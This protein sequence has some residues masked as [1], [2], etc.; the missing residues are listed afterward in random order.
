MKTP[1]LLLL[2]AAVVCG[3]SSRVRSLQPQRRHVVITQA[4]AVERRLRVVGALGVG[5]VLVALQGDAAGGETLAPESKISE[6][7]GRSEGRLEM[8]VAFHPDVLQSEMD[9]ILLESGVERIEHPDLLPAHRLVRISPEQIRTISNW[10]EVSRIFSA[11]DSLVSGSPITGCAGP[12]T[13]VGPVANYMATIGEGWDGA[14]RWSADLMFSISVMTGKVAADVLAETI[15][16]VLAE[17]SRHAA[18]RFTQTVRTDASRNINFMFSSR[19]HGDPYPF[20]GRGGILAHTFYPAGV[21]PEPVA[22]DVHLD[23]E[24]TWSMGGSPDLYSVLLHEV[25]HALGLGHSDRREAV[26]YP[27]YKHST[28]LHAADIATLRML[29]APP[30]GSGSGCRLR[31]SDQYDPWRIPTPGKHCNPVEGRI[32]VPP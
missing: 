22:G 5:R 7:I 27:Y 25:G 21:N 11:S 12:V 30:E 31:N 8:V 17:W 2:A 28:V 29:Y 16:N 26:M 4:E 19:D 6:A 15:N 32:S 14:G 1:F 18:I 10:D 13:E 20:D 24:E 3:A 9:Q 23:E